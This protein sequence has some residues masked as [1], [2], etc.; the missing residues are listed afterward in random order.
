[1]SFSTKPQSRK[2]KRTQRG[3]TMIEVAMAMG[4]LAVGATG[5][6]AMQ[7]VAVVGNASAR[8]IS[9]STAIANRW[10]ERLRADAMVWNSAQ[11][12]DINETRWLK[13]A[14]IS[15]DVWTLPAAYANQ[16][17]P[18]ADPIGADIVDAADPAITAYCTHIRYRFITP[19]MINSTIRVTY[20]RNFDAIDCAAPILFDMTADIAQ[21]GYGAVYI[22]T[23]SMV[24]ELP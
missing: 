15:P 21:A 6:I 23:G 22:T 14:A 7:K 2:T 11:P 12:S 13:T 18:E 3:Y 20:R 4:V 24:Q 5:V 10:A 19:K 9:A 17:S 16:A 8:S 1:M